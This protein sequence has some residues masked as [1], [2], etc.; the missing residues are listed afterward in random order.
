MN[1]IKPSFESEELFLPPPLKK[2][3]I[4]QENVVVDTTKEN[5]IVSSSGDWLK[6]HCPTKIDELGVHIRKV[7]ELENWLVQSQSKFLLLAGPSGCGKTTTLEIVC[8]KLHF[9]LLEW[10]TPVDKF[11]TAPQLSIIKRFEEFL[12]KTSKYDSCFSLHSLKTVILVKDFPTVF[13]Q[14]PNLFYEVLENVSNLTLNNPIIFI[15]GDSKVRR[16]LFSSKMNLKIQVIWFNP[17]TN[18]QMLRVLRLI[19]TRERE[20]NKHFKVP[21][22]QALYAICSSSK[23]DIRHGVLELYFQCME[24][25]DKKLLTQS[26]DKE[27]SKDYRVDFFQGIGNV[28]TPRKVIVSANRNIQF[29]ATPD[30]LIESFLAEAKD[31]VCRLN[32]N[33]YTKFTNFVDLSEA[34]KRLATSD[35]L[36]AKWQ[37]GIFQEYSLAVAIRG[38]MVCNKHPRET[39]FQYYGTQRTNNLERTL[40]GL[41]LDAKFL[42]SDF[43]MLDNQCVNDYLCFAKYLMVGK[44]N[45][46]QEKYLL[47][48]VCF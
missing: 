24:P 8:K 43:Y 2:G 20:S 12:V 37:E 41:Q 28:L 47:K 14:N 36:M 35:L 17:I 18:L 21:T 5:Q 33:F 6:I 4:H 29:G 42:F 1:W 48:H 3:C 22:D 40:K 16:M 11:A 46:S 26:G 10:I 13:I 15:C 34:A 45:P 23:G 9:K 32:E 31:F 25:T 7:E 39:G 44:L 30:T 38:V 19:I 27:K